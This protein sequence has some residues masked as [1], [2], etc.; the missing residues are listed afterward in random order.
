MDIKDILFSLSDKACIGSV[1]EASFEAEKYLSAF[2]STE[3][4]NNNTVIGT[5]KGKG[6]YTL[7]LDAH[8]DEVGFVVTAVDD[9]GFLT[10]AKCGGIDLRTLPA[11]P[12]LIHGKEKITGVFCST[13][14]HLNSGE[15]EFDDISKLKIDTMLG[16]RAKELVSVGDFVTY[17]TKPSS[18]LG[19]KVC[20]KSFDD[21]A[22][23]A[24]LIELAK[25]LSGK[26]L[27]INVTF[28]L[29]DMEELGTR[30][31]ITAAYET[32]PDEAV[33]IDV[34]FGD[35]P[36]VSADECGKLSGGAMIGV[37]PTLDSGV[38]DR[39]FA[40][41]RDNGIKYQTEVMSG[42]TGTNGDVISVSRSGVKTG[43]VSI[44][45]RNMHTDC[46]IVDIDD[47]LSVCDILENYILGAK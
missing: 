12:V 41:A 6:D 18:L 17:A 37:S 8:I 24:I 9:N 13:P 3:R 34:S 39:L 31:A 23:V 11:R 40:A 46:E 35:A 33:A 43:L 26:V 5:L 45:L 28:V 2:M 16:G 47:L 15:M 30:G 27:P 7:M 38:T 1:S 20:G 10:V 44:P 25:R 32:A 21:R 42:R 4:K 19:N 14:P 29:S 22:G 36:D